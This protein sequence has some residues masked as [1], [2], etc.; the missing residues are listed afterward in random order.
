MGKAFLSRSLY[1]LGLTV[2]FAALAAAQTSPADQVTEFEVNGMKVLVKRRP[3]APTVA[4]GIYI[5]GGSRNLTEKDQGIE[6]LML[7]S[8][9]DAGTK[10]SRAQVR[11]E[12]SR[13]G[14]AI[15]GASNRD[16]GAIAF[17]TT[18]PNFD[19]VW[20]IFT[21]VVLTP[22]FDSADIERNRTQLQTGLRE[23]E[24]SPESA[25][26][27]NIDRIIYA[28][29]PYANDPS[30]TP[31]TL[32]SLTPEQIKAYHKRVMQ[33]SQLLMVF[34]GDLDPADMK[35]RITKAFGQ[36]PRGNYVDRPAAPLQFTK[37]TVNVIARP[38]LPTNYIE[39]VFAAPS[40]ADP[41]YYPMR[42]AMAVLQSLVYQEVRVRRQ[43][44]YAPG[45]EMDNYQ[46]NTANITVTSTDA[47]QSVEVMLEQMQ[48]LRERTLLDEVLGEIADNFLTTYYLGQETSAAQA[49]ELARYELI[50]GGWRN[51]FEFINKMHQ[52]TGR[53]VNAVANKYM[54]DLRFVVVG[55][56]KAVNE[57]V[58][59][60]S[61][62]N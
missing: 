54:K 59:L 49:A 35:A 46:A 52:V 32:A 5:R 37:P 38:G 28:G 3:S 13:T 26:Q 6:S 48:F 44:S 7:A 57:S 14:S 50:G 17:A 62:A 45:A 11:R 22:A 39:G 8:A 41:D 16:F 47:N 53:D 58:F 20:D 19:R 25:L 30:G 43:L 15:S 12:L 4:G 42:I 31:A 23:A 29:H 34:V 18:R 51:S 2:V 9:T 24:T 61:T 1:I 56:P 55:D 36:L 21:D 60:K 27:S 10:F 40:L 33:T